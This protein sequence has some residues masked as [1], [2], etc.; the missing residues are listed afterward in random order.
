MTATSRRHRDVTPPAGT[1]P[2]DD[3]P[4]QAGFIHAP[5]AAQAEGT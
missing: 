2:D 1:E 4:A 3:S 5:H